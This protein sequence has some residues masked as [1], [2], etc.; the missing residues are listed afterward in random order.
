MRNRVPRLHLLI[1]PVSPERPK[2]AQAEA[3]RAGGDASKA[4]AAAKRAEDA[5]ARAEAAAAKSEKIFKLEQKK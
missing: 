2:A 4:E 1:G 3:T 5:A